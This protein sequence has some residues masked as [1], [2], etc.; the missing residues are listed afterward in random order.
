MADATDSTETVVTF[1]AWHEAHR[2]PPWLT[3]PTIEIRRATLDGT[4]YRWQ[5]TIS[6]TSPADD[7]ED[8]G[9]HLAVFEDGLA[10]FADIPQFFAALGAQ[11]PT[12]LS[13]VATILHSLGIAD[14]TVREAPA[15]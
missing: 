2:V 5:F 9:L 3:K 14:E 4:E 11:R 6:D 1:T 10:A 7:R 15:R 13:E 12:H 8:G